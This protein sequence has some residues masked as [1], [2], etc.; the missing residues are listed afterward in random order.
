MM[1]LPPFVYLAPRELDE[2][3]RLLADHG[4]E[5]MPVA[6][7]TD[8]FPNM[9]RRQVEPKVLVGLRGLR[10][11]QGITAEADG[12][13]R[14]GAGVVL[15]RIVEHPAVVQRVPVLARAAA[16]ISNPQIRCMGT[17]GGN[18]LVDTR[19]NYYNMPYWWR[20]AI[21]FC[22]KKDGDTCWV[23]P[24]GHRCWAISSSD[25]APVLVA[26][27]AQVRLAGA[28]GERTIPVADLYRDDGIVYLGKAPDEV[29]VE[30][31]V[32]PADGLR[33]TYWK[34][35]RRGAIDFPILGVAAAVRMAPDGTCTAARIVLGA[36]ASQP[37]RCEAAERVLLGQQ[38]GPAVIDAAAEA[39]WKPAK[40]L[41]NADLTL[42]YRKAM[43]RV[44]VRRALREVAGLPVADV[45]PSAER[46]AV[47]RTEHW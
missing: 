8:L 25:L 18:L 45:A 17:V 33:A 14:I 28:R 40:P 29:L 24:G 13:L 27:E 11:L 7:G 42:G 4:P 21:D 10:E 23:A 19:C 34:L 6:G 9:K 41:D 35:R 2:A 32:P 1:R 20:R 12:G 5:A 36:V 3:V 31:R 16:T 15:R 43:V 38:L 30:V 26:L 22:M 44:Y 39:A 46:M 47:R 37:V